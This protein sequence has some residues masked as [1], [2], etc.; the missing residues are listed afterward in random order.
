MNTNQYKSYFLLLTSYFLLLAG[1]GDRENKSLIPDSNIK[2]EAVGFS[3]TATTK[4]ARDWELNAEKAVSYEDRIIVYTIR[5]DFYRNKKIYST[6][7]ADSGIYFGETD[8]MKAF[9]DVKVVTK[10]GK[11]LETSE[12]E[13]LNKESKI[14]TDKEIKITEQDKTIIGKGLESNPDLTCIKIRD[15]YGYGR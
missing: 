10:E 3:L 11:N 8:N 5:L 12:L 13:W 14:R 1:C 4:G 2:E 6:L 7:T 15:T 9:G